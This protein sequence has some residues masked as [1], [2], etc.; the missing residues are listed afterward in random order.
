MTSLPAPT[1]PVDECPDCQQQGKR[2]SRVLIGGRGIY[3]CPDG[4]MWQD[5]D[6]QPNYKGTIPLGHLTAA[7]EDSSA[8]AS[9]P[10]L[11][12]PGVAAGLGLVPQT[13]PYPVQEA[14]DE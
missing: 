7:L 12:R 3:R 2:D 4:H 13:V 5:A 14:G 1:P 8:S 10:V 11:Q 6:E 9:L